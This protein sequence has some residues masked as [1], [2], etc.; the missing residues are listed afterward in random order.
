MECT[1]DGGGVCTT[2]ESYPD[3]AARARIRA[4][5]PRAGVL[6]SRAGGGGGSGI[7]NASEV[8][9]FRRRFSTIPVSTMHFSMHNV[10]TIFQNIGSACV[11]PAAA[12]P[13]SIPETSTSA[14][15]SYARASTTC[16]GGSGGRERGDADLAGEPAASS[17]TTQ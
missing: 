2:A 3:L 17:A 7:G 4:G 13:S 14:G 1:E 11:P 16:A 9:E 8:A 15:P 12:Y 6:P 5:P 10:L